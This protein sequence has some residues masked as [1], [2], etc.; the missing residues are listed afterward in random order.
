MSRNRKAALKSGFFYFFKLIYFFRRRAINP[1]P[2]KPAPRRRIV[3]GSGTLT[4][5]LIR[6][7]AKVAEAQ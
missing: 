3:P 6:S 7:L 5:P 2:V 4:F 1:K